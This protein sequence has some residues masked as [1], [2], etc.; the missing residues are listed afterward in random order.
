MWIIYMLIEF[1]K[2]LATFLVDFFYFIWRYTIY[3]FFESITKN[4]EKIQTIKQENNK[5][6]KKS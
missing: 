6:I 2:I 3:Y 1:P 4:T 5:T